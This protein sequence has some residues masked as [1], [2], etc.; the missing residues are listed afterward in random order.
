AF[1]GDRH[2]QRQDQIDLNALALGLPQMKIER[3]PDLDRRIEIRHSG[4]SLVI[5][6]LHRN[7]RVEADAEL[8]IL[9]VEELTAHPFAIGLEEFAPI[10]KIGDRNWIRSR[11]VRAAIVRKHERPDAEPGLPERLFFRA[12]A[13]R[14]TR[15]EN[16]SKETLRACAHRSSPRERYLSRLVTHATRLPRAAARYA[17]SAPPASWSAR[18][19]PQRGPRG[20]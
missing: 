16:D 14:E 8:R 20:R 13:A 19:A 3:R 4:S 2:A 6:A 18:I 11:L 12:H 9:S 15:E 1:D 7:R 10:D 5:V 17:A